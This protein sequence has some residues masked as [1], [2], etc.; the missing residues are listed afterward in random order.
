[1]ESAEYDFAG[2]PIV[3]SSANPIRLVILKSGSYLE[4]DIMP[5]LKFLEMNST[6]TGVHV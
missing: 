5:L 1:L 4:G 2:L 3:L 6:K